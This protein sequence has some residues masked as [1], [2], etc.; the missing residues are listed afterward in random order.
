MISP[1]EG[2]IQGFRVT[3]NGSWDCVHC[4]LAD[5]LRYRHALRDPKSRETFFSGVIS[6]ENS[7]MGTFSGII[8]GMFSLKIMA[9]FALDGSLY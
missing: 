6:Y 7:P 3:A 9:D 2:S 1:R 5:V 8:P 4:T